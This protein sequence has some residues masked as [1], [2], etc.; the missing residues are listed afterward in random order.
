MS[1]TNNKRDITV[2]SKVF[3]SAMPDII[4]EEAF[5][6]LLSKLNTS[7][8]QYYVR[9]KPLIMKGLLHICKDSRTISDGIKL[10]GGSFGI[11]KK[12]S[13]GRIFIVEDNEAVTLLWEGSVASYYDNWQLYR[14]KIQEKY[15]KADNK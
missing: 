13:V 7:T 6:E 15:S 14:N 3:L 12:Q 11:G 8:K 4:S 9:L 1:D 5:E 10:N 2:N